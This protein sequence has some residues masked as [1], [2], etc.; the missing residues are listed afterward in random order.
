[1]SLLDVLSIKG[2]KL[3]TILGTLLPCRLCSASILSAALDA[4]RPKK[5]EKKEISKE[6]TKIQSQ[7]YRYIIRQKVQVFQIYVSVCIVL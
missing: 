1:M 6:D 3:S 5:Q 4:A 2:V 7:R